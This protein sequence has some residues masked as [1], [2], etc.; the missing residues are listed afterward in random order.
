MKQIAKLI[1]NTT[2]F[3]LFLLLCS[4]VLLAKTPDGQ[5]P[6]EETVCDVLGE[7][8]VTPDA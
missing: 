8:G 5:P 1:A 7:P 4:G 3:S 2:A 6:S